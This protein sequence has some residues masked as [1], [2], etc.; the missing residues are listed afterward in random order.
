MRYPVDDLK[1]LWRLLTIHHEQGIPELIKLFQFCLVMT[2]QT[3]DCEK[4]I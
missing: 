4:N 1:K 2:L 3:A